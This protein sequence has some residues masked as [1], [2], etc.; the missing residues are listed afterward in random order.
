MS[1]SSV[2]STSL[3]LVLDYTGLIKTDI[4]NRVMT[5]SIVVVISRLQFLK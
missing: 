5:I 1:Y 4:E 3:S 2:S